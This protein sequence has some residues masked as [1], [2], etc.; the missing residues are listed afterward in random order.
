MVEIY[1]TELWFPLLSAFIQSCSLS[2]HMHLVPRVWISVT[3]A[4]RTE[5][6]LLWVSDGCI[7]NW[8]LTSLYYCFVPTVGPALMGAKSTQTIVLHIHHYR[9]CFCFSLVNAN[10][11]IILTF[12]HCTPQRSD[13]NQVEC[14]VCW[15]S[16]CLFPLDFSAHIYQS[17]IKLISYQVS[18]YKQSKTKC[19]IVSIS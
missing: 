2:L 13:V 15:V 8:L 16:L 17:L 19:E 3:R 11:A 14:G 18:Y 4:L 6:E 10:T 1:K 9:V 12:S 7:T 5:V